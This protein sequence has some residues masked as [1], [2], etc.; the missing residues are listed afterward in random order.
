MSITHQI[1]RMFYACMVVASAAWAGRCSPE[2]PIQP[3]S[4][5]YLAEAARAA[6]GERVDKSALV[7]RIKARYEVV[8]SN[9]VIV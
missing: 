9:L 5:A 7:T 2:D 3:G 4:A 1:E 8:P 6:H